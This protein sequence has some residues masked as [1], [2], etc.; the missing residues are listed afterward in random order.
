MSDSEWFD[1]QKRPVVVEARGPYYD[2]TTVETLEGEFEVTDEYAERGFYI[3][4]GVEG[5]V[6]PCQYDIFHDTYRVM[7]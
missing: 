3:I 4:R 1:V 5:E 2:P 6:Y 7:E